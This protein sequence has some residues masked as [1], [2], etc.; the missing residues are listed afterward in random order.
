MSGKTHVVGHRTPRSRISPLGF[1]NQT[2]G[3]VNPTTVEGLLG[4]S[5]TGTRQNQ[6]YTTTGISTAIT[7]YDAGRRLAYRSI[8]LDTVPG[9]WAAAATGA[10]DAQI[11]TFCQ[12]VQNAA[13]WNAAN[14]FLV[15]L[16]HE[17]TLSPF[18]TATFTAS[19]YK[20][21]WQHI[22]PFCDSN[23]WT[24]HRSDGTYNA[25]G[26]IDFALVGWDRMFV[27]ANGIGGPT[28]GQGIDDVDP[29]SQ[30]YRYLGSDV[31]NPIDSPGVLRYS[32][33]ASLLVTPL[34]NASISRGKDFIIGEMGCEDAATSQDHTNKAA[35][36][37]SFRSL[38]LARGAHKPGVCRALLL[39]IKASAENYNVDSSPEA[40]AAFQRLA[41]STY[42][43]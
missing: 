40:L 19:D 9:G 3:G 13:R 15:C 18:G 2:L 12:N 5:F 26:V 6:A 24:V 43:S 23:G 20:A 31:Y 34:I 10:A 27:G 25:N 14:P 37:D 39:T 41:A 28:A 17:C 42:F 4:R 38:I 11:T 33:D 32:T 16:H 29:G 7:D 36:I 8:Q 1:G 21:M 35:W 30:Y 22:V